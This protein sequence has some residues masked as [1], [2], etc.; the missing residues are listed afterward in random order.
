MIIYNQQTK[1]QPMGIL[2][3]NANTKVS[4]CWTITLVG[5]GVGVVNCQETSLLDCAFQVKAEKCGGLLDT[6]ELDIT[7]FRVSLFSLEEH[8]ATLLLPGRF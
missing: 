2:T 1:E 4:G 3:A 7:E 8:T 5:V 6:S